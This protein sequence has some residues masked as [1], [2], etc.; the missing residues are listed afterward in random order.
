MDMFIY[1][2]SAVV[3]GLSIT[4]LVF[5][6]AIRAQRLPSRVDPAL[7]I[8]CESL[9]VLFV[10]GLLALGGVACYAR[11]FWLAGLCAILL[12]LVFSIITTVFATVFGTDERAKKQA[13][14]LQP[15]DLRD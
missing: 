11:H 15:P 13:R 8:I 1:H 10:L 6:L 4:L 9:L 14:F 5:L 2:V 7:H 3:A 12:A